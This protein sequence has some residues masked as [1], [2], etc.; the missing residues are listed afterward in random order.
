MITNFV[1]STYDKNPEIFVGASPNSLVNKNN[2]PTMI[3]QGTSDELVPASQS[4]NLKL[5]LDSLGVPNVYYRLPLWPHTM[6]I[7]QRVNN[8]CQVKM[9]AFFKQYL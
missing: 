2:P 6:D 5:R 1:G 4:D 9:D 8:F 3:L 7:V